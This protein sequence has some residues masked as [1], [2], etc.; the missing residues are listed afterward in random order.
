MS[1]RHKM[2]GQP[3][4]LLHERAD[5]MGLFEDAT[6]RVV[7]SMK[8]VESDRDNDRAPIRIPR[9]AWPIQRVRSA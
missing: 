8:M 4:R 2:T 9:P 6:G 5:G 7:C 3:L 1:H